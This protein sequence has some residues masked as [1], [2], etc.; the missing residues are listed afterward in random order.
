MANAKDAGFN[1]ISID[2]IY[3]LPDM[4]TLSWQKNLEIAFASGIQHLSAY[5]LTIEPNSTF[6]RMAAKGIIKNIPDEQSLSQFLLL[7]KTAEEQGFIHYEISNLAREGY[8]SKHNSNYWLQKK[9]LGI[10]PSAH[11]YNVESRQWNISNITRYVDAINKGLVYFETED[12]NSKIRFNEYLMLSLRTIWGI[13]LE[14]IACDFGEKAA[15]CFK[16]DI[17]RFELSGDLIHHENIY[18]L[19]EKGWLISDFIISRLMQ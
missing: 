3:G 13:D 4:N 18:T 9:Y 10:G 5:H 2:L 19:T 15:A 7:R 8:F 1:N 16:K 12:L 6:A 17:Q 11:S 14:K